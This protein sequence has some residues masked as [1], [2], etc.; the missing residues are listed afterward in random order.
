[1]IKLWSYERALNKTNFIWNWVVEPYKKNWVV[2][3]DREV[4][5]FE[6]SVHII[7]SIKYK[8]MKL[9]LKEVSNS[10]HH[11]RCQIMSTF[12]PKKNLFTF[13][14]KLL[15][16]KIFEASVQKSSVYYYFFI[17]DFFYIKNW[18]RR[19]II[20]KILMFTFNNHRV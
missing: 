3:N 17:V 7:I 15:S 10:N 19:L 12:F 13:L 20:F 6:A 2:E 5:V 16:K 18:V 1:M 11:C 8:H 9:F 4:T 14:L